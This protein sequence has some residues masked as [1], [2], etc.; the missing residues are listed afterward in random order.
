MTSTA[1]ATRKTVKAA[2]KKT[3]RM[4]KER[5]AIWLKWKTDMSNH[6]K[7]VFLREHICSGFNDAKS[8]LDWTMFK[9]CEWFPLADSYGS[10]KLIYGPLPK[11]PEKTNYAIEHLCR[12]GNHILSQKI[13]SINSEYGQKIKNLLSRYP[14][15]TYWLRKPKVGVYPGFCQVHTSVAEYGIYEISE[16]I[17]NN[18]IH[19]F[20]GLYQGEQENDENWSHVSTDWNV[21]KTLMYGDEQCQLNHYPTPMD[22][23]A[24]VNRECESDIGT[25]T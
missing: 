13:K 16:D 6:Y 10:I 11:K 5:K 12:I 25:G 2:R 1:E 23:F 4:A 17:F 14:Q 15:I 7:D 8:F 19:L 18:T 9:I 3:R 21:F 22:N 20:P 24:I